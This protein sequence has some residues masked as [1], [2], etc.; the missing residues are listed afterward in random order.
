[1]YKTIPNLK[2]AKALEN[3]ELYLL[4]N[5]G[6][7]GKIDL[8]EVERKGLFSVWEKHFD[9]FKIEGNI[10]SWDENCEVDADSF[11]LKLIKK[12]FFE[13]AGN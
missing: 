3:Y 12:D 11:Y 2:E 7:E 10:L 1:M 9:K 13:Y 4:F 6:V 5:D 8:S